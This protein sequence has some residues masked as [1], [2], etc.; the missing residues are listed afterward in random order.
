MKKQIGLLTLAVCILVGC[1]P[2]PTPTPLQI[3]P[4]LPKQPIQLLSVEVEI[5]GLPEDVS[6][7]LSVSKPPSSQPIIR[8]ERGTGVW[9]LDLPLYCDFC[10]VTANASGY[11]S[12]PIS[13]TIKVIDGNPQV[14]AA[15]NKTT[16]RAIFTFTANP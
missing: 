9:N 10:V 13:Y 6:V 2:I 5:S 3:T 11:T 1:Q 14:Y 16:D 4:T 12:T 7:S 8:G 15:D